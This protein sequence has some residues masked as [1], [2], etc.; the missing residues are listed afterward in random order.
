MFKRLSNLVR[1][2][3]S[4]LIGGLEKRNPEALLEVE[5]ENLREQISKYNQG[6]AS[7]AA[8]CERLISQVKKLEGDERDLRAKTTA[9]LR[10][11]N[12]DVAGHYAV[13]LQTVQRELEEDRQQ[14]EQ[15]EKTYRELIKARDVAVRAAQA[16]IEALRHNLNDLRVKKATAELAEMASGMI[17][18][19]GGAGDTLDRLTH[20]VNEEREV[21]AGRVRIAR[22][23]VDMTEISIKEGEQKALADQA[24]ADFAA[25]EG[26]ALDG[27]SSIPSG[28]GTEGSTSR[29]M[30][31]IP[32]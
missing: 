14:L 20:M 28:D 16:K 31:P 9:N 6:L 23:S 5:K 25:K 29:S 19:L 10:A 2:F 26:I 1:G 13:Q 32:Q 22:D 17:S 12:R 18:Q 11:G 3:F 4:L 15:A 7:H 8:L 21:A 27:P 24:L 30:G